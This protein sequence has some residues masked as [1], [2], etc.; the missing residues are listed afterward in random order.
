MSVRDSSRTSQF[1]SSIP[2]KVNCPSENY[3]NTKM[4]LSTRSTVIAAEH[5]DEAK[6]ENQSRCHDRPRCVLARICFVLRAI[7]WVAGPAF[8]STEAQP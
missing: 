4:I 8:G 5:G 2:S 6:H 7:F 1:F 3:L